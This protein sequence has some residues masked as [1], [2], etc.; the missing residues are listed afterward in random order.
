MEERPQSLLAVAVV[1]PLVDVGREEGRHAPEPLEEDL[2]DLVLFSGVD[3]HAEG[4]DVEDLHVVRE[5][6]LELE[7]KRVIVPGEGPAV[8]VRTT[9]GADRKLISDDDDAVLGDGGGHVGGNAYSA[10][11]V[12]I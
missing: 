9:A 6:A 3:V 2:C 1:E 8:A 11:V 4:A 12:L 5:A 7:E 10:V